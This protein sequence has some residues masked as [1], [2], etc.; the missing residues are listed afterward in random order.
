M[1]K[2]LT[3]TLAVLFVT[4]S[5]L[6]AQDFNSYYNI[7]KRN[8]NS[9]SGG[10]NSQLFI[11]NQ[12]NSSEFDSIKK[13]YSNSSDSYMGKSI[14]TNVPAENKSKKSTIITE[15]HEVMEVRKKSRA[16]TVG[17]YFGVDFI[18][19][20]LRYYDGG[21][22]SKDNIASGKFTRN[23]NSEKYKNSF[24]LKYFYALNYHGFFLAPELFFEY[25][26]VKKNTEDNYNQNPFYNERA[27]W[28]YGNEF[29]KIHKIY[30]GKINFGYDVNPDFAPF[31]FAGISKIYYSNRNSVYPQTAINGNNP[32]A[33][34]E[35]NSL[36]LRQYLLDNNQKN[37][38]AIMRNSTIA[39]FFGFGGKI[40]LSERFLLSAEYLIYNKFKASKVY[41]NYNIDNFEILAQN[42][43]HSNQFNADLRV[44]K[45][46]LL[47]N[48]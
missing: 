10:K 3:L 5:N 25:N 38:F 31:V 19:T 14:K 23:A 13:R 15:Y 32:D 37:P 29:L 9:Y 34:T 12:Q 40:K 17:N 41:K 36:D 35:N 22:E 43:A 20:N 42:S 44:A 27:P 18:N 7:Y 39:S 33:L 47:Y 24:G 26:N 2:I 45:I 28:R 21:I 30:G 1:K 16:R 8:N 48:F 46:G 11:K 4:I 6:N